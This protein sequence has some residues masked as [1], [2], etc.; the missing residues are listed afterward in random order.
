M[1]LFAASSRVRVTEHQVKLAGAR[2]KQNMYSFPT[3]SSGTQL[4]PQILKRWL[5]LKISSEKKIPWE[6][7]EIRELLQFR[8]SLNHQT[9][10]SVRELPSDTCPIPVFSSCLS[11]DT[12]L[13]PT[14]T[15]GSHLTPERIRGSTRTTLTTV[16]FPVTEQLQ[17][18][19]W[20]TQML[21]WTSIFSWLTLR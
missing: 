12:A 11:G 10:T 13:A 6:L 3:H 18:G 8:N 9:R 21:S 17:T 4:L 14:I 1:D 16:V 7:L 20:V 5:N 19:L 15:E 2:E